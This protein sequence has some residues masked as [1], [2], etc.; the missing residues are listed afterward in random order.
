[1]TRTITTPTIAALAALI[2][3]TAPARA[4]TCNLID[5]P[6][7]VG[8]G[9]TLVIARPDGREMCFTI[10]KSAGI[11]AGRITVLTVRPVL[12]ASASDIEVL[13]TKERTATK[14]SR[15]HH[16]ADLSAPDLFGAAQ[17]FVNADEDRHLT[18]RVRPRHGRDYRVAVIV[19]EIEIA[20]VI[21]AAT[22]DAFA[23]VALDIFM[24][25]LGVKDA[26]LPF[27]D[28]RM[29]SIGLKAVSG[30]AKGHSGEEIVAGIAIQT[31]IKEMLAGADV[32]RELAIVVASFITHAWREVAKN[33]LRPFQWPLPDYERD[34]SR[35]MA[36]SLRN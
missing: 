3:T 16:A 33:A 18:V 22:I 21:G 31:A 20:E 32:P 14:G 24:R 2:V 1:M 15:P 12:N 27:L 9:H 34:T 25:E 10:N 4:G 28:H 8:Q 35:P 17:L 36:A 6:T 5:P 13:V 7:L 23:H 19:H 26:K 11:S 30:A 29:L